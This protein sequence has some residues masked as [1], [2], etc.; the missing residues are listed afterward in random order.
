MSIGNPNYT[1][2]LG[3]RFEAIAYERRSKSSWGIT[4]GRRNAIVAMIH[5][6]GRVNKSGS[7]SSNN[8]V[9]LP[10]LYDTVGE[11]DMAT[12]ARSAQEQFPS[13][14]PNYLSIDGFTQAKYEYVYLE[15]RYPITPKESLVDT[16]ERK[17]DLREG[18]RKA[19]EI[20]HAKLVNEF[21]MADTLGSE[22]TLTGMPYILSTANSPGG[23]NQATN[24]WWRSQVLTS[25]GVLAEQ[26]L[27]TYY[28]DVADLTGDMGEP[29]N[30]DLWMASNRRF[31]GS[32]NTPYNKVRNFASSAQRIVDMKRK[33]KYG[34]IN[35]VYMDALVVPNNH[36]NMANEVWG[37]STKALHWWGS[38]APNY[39]VGRIPG[40]HATEVV[41]GY[42][43]CFGTDMP[44]AMVRIKDLTG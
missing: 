6:E 28:D 36:V 21:L 43:M 40:S 4:I 24:S 18:K 31:T 9:I 30:I 33:E 10:L 37:L 15:A 14:W 2:H 26:Q 23:I 11:L 19:F 25:A 5:A 32:T 8:G 7:P 41:A 38:K 22:K 35:L 12:Y 1:A 3:G 42:W 29:F 20:Q 16:G 27:Q 17:G 13:Q 44:A 39:A 34:L